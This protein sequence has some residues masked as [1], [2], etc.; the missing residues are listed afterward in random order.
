MNSESLW[1]LK[2]KKNKTKEEILLLKLIKTTSS[3]NELLN[4]NFKKEISD[5]NTLK[6]I[7][8]IIYNIIN[9]I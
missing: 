8:N 5:K 1:K 7:S 3:I 2:K 9:E 6:K 4:S